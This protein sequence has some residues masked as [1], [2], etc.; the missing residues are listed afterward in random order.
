RHSGRLPSP[1]APQLTSKKAGLGSPSP[2]YASGVQLLE[3][4]AELSALEECIAS[5]DQG[6]GRL[7]VISGEAGVGKTS[8]VRE[9]RS[10]SGSNVRVLWGQC[11]PLHTP[12]PLGPVVDV[13]RAAGGDLAKLADS[14]DRHRLFAE[15]I[16]ACSLDGPV[17]VLVLED[18]HWADAAS[19]DF[20][21]Y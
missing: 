4:E 12:R 2:A 13:A 9:L 6:E 7:V 19:L 3:R 11:E 15:L 8:L 5:A 21:A 14:D 16:A 20:L 1:G 18:L 10:S 17:T